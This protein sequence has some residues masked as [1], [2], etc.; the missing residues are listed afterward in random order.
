MES[1]NDKYGLNYFSDSKLD[2]ESD[3]AE[4]Y[5][6]EHKYEKLIKT[7]EIIDIGVKDVKVK[8]MYFIFF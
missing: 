3:E 6:Y 5:R 4:E 1:F 7:F 2:S 8:Y